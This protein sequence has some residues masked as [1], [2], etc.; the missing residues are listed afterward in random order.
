MRGYP[1]ITRE[2]F[3]AIC[4]KKKIELLYMKGYRGVK[5]S[6]DFHCLVCGYKWQTSLIKFP[7]I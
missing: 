4:V 7:H 3:N 2:E 1:E 6:H 5:N